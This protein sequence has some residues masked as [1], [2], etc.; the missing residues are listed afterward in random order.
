MLRE[1]RVP[2]PEQPEST[3]SG[4]TVI[5]AVTA[6]FDTKGRKRRLRAG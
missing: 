4:C 6:A 3:Q 5:A 1:T 2:W